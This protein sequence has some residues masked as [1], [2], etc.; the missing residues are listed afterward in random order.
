MIEMKTF[1]YI[2]LTDFVFSESGEKVVKANV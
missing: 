1:L 2:L